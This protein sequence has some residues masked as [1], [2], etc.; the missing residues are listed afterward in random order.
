MEVPTSSSA[1]FT[2]TTMTTVE[3]TNADTATVNQPT[4]GQSTTSS[5]TQTVSTTIPTAKSVTAIHAT[6]APAMDTTILSSQTSSNGYENTLMA[7]STNY[8]TTTSISDQIPV[9]ATTTDG[10]TTVAFQTEITS[11]DSSGIAAHK[12]RYFVWDRI[13]FWNL[14]WVSI[15]YH[16]ITFNV[17]Q[18]LS[19]RRHHISMYRRDV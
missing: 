13:L 12:I 14:Y 18:Y 8:P 15:P 9:A 16:S 19:V 17:N 5:R 2:P 6:M 10:S 3:I 1:S 4:N 11:I 7:M